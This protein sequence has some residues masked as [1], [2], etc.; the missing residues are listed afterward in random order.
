MLKHEMYF[1]VTFSFTVGGECGEI[2]RTE[3]REDY[4]EN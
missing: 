4:K 1:R 3:K 2:R